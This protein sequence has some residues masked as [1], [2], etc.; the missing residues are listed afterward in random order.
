MFINL[1]AQDIN[2]LLKN[3]LSFKLKYNHVLYAIYMYKQIHS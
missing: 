1:M 3:D 2:Q